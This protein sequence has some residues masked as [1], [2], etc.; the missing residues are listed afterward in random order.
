MRPSSQPT[1]RLSAFEREYYEELARFKQLCFR[2]IDQGQTYQAVVLN[3]ELFRF[4]YPSEPYASFVHTDPVPFALAHLRRLMVLGE[5]LLDLVKGYHL[6]PVDVRPTDLD[7][8]TNTSNLY[9]SLWDRFDREAL[10]AD[11]ARLLEQRLQA[12]VIA[13]HVRGKRVL[14]MGCGSGRYALAL[15]AAGAGEVM[16]IDH[17]RKA[18]RRAEEYAESTALPVCFME[19][20]VLRLPFSD[21]SFDFVFCNGVLH[22]TRDWSRGVTEYARVMKRSGYLYLYAR[23]GFFWTARNVMREIFAK[24]P[25]DYTQMVLTI[26]G[27]PSNRF[28]FMDTWYVP[29]ESHIARAELEGLIEG[30]GLRWSSMRSESSFDPNFALSANIPG[31]EIVWGEGE[32]RYLVTRQ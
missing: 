13:E 3:H 24:I 1:F 26:M 6:A 7:V 32:H 16:A 31:A 14:D 4:L 18:F 10:I 30:L 11:A 2:L 25:K 8:E 12:D 29:I 9:Y 5:S 21:R 15:A 17:Q 23:G 28:I 20:D 27:L 19:A 22:H